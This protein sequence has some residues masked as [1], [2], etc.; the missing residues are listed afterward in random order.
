MEWLL[1]SAV[2]VERQPEA[3]VII[4]RL[5]RSVVFSNIFDELYSRLNSY[6]VYL[7][8]D[9]APEITQKSY[10]LFVGIKS[11]RANDSVYHLFV[12][13]KIFYHFLVASYHPSNMAWVI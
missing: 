3:V 9:Q 12:G 7:T 10:H 11:D 2:N 1:V 13:I 4:V 8:K 5:R 6:Q